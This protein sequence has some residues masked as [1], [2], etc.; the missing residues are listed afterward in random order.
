MKIEKAERF[1]ITTAGLIK[2]TACS[3]ELQLI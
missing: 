2:K 3:A 1:Q